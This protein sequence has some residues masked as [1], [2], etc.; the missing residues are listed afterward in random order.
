ML[1]SEDSTV[2]YTEFVPK[3]VYLEFM[4]PED[5]ILPAEEQPLHVAIFPTTDSPAYVLESYLEEDPKEDLEEDDKDPKEDQAD[6]PTD[7]EDDDD[8]KEEESS[9]DDADDEEENEDEEEEEEHPALA[10]SVRPPAH[11]VMTRMFVRAQ[12]PHITSFRDR[13]FQTSCHTYPTTITTLSIVITTTLRLCIA[14]G[15]IFE[16]GESSSAP[17]A[18]PTKGFRADYGFVVT[19]DDEIRRDPKREVGYGITDTWNEMVEDMLG[20]PIATDVVGLSQRMI[21]FVT[22]VRRDTDEIYRRLDDR[23]LMSGQLN[24]LRRDRRAHARITRLIKNKARVSREAWI[25]SMDASDTARAEVLYFLVIEEIGT[26]KNNKDVP[27][28]SNKIKRYIDGLSDMIRRSVMTSKPKTM[29]DAIKF[30]TELMD[31]KISTFAERQAKNK[32]K[33]KGTSKNNQNQQQNKK[34]NTNRAY[35]VGSGDKKPYVG[36]KLLCSK[37][38]Y[39]HDGHFKRECPKLKNNNRGNEGRNGNA[40]AKVYAI[41]HAGTNP[42]SNVITDTFLLNNRYASISFDTGVDR[43]FVSTAFISQIE[44][45]DGRIIGLNTIIQGFTLKFLNHPFNINL[46]LIELGSFNVITGMDWLAKYQSIIVYAKKII[47]IP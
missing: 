35:T 38:N 40:P 47:R 8:D 32:R 17:T 18:R 21:D 36:S 24:M 33:F 13:D 46:M 12:T 27:E 10:D 28:E 16:V 31:K 37:F 22:T 9:R 41:G 2:T 39:R 29:Q 4:P 42:D 30:T 19:L 3:P 11:R 34:Q 1:D 15:L 26:K 43:S 25:Q 7:R 45:A 5:D 23:L 20:T 6:Y 14:L 44:L